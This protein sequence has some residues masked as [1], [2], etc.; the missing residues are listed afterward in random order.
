MIY[1]VEKERFIKFLY[2][3]FF[4]VGLIAIW[5]S[6]M[7]F[8]T[9]SW[10]FLGQVFGVWGLTALSLQ[11]LLGSR[12][13]VLER[14]IGLDRILKIH[15]LNGR[16]LFIFVL[17]HP[18]VLFAPTLFGGLSLTQLLSSFTIYHWMGVT[19]LVL[20]IFILAT[21]IYSAA[22]RVNYEVWKVLHKI[23]Y[24][25]IILGFAHSFYLGSD[26]TSKGVL[27][28]WWIVL[29]T[30]ALLGISYR[31]IIKSWIFRNSWYK[32]IDVI[33]E[34]H[35]IRTII[36]E[37]L[38]GKVFNFVPGQF[39]YVNFYSQQVPKEEHH[40]TISSAPNPNYLSFSIKASGDFTSKLGDLKIGEKAKI[41]GPYGVFTNT[42]MKEPFLFIAGGIGITPVMSILRKMQSEKIK[43]QSVLIYANK[44]PEDTAF[45]DELNIME[46]QGLIKIVYVFSNE[47]EIKFNK[48]FYQGKVE[49][50]I[51]KT[52]VK[53]IKNDTVFLVGPP[54]MIDA[55]QQILQNLGVDKRKIFTEKFSL[56]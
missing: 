23:A 44:S 4:L 32:V 13:P 8:F 49:E 18:I 51:L 31:Y 45:E 43:G 34:T 24:V 1:N 53:D 17:L 3:A 2:I 19:A 9:L 35:D 11:P 30:L 14:G 5:A 16:L 40:F 37:P 21:T 6:Q 42:G 33:Q 12:M 46:R 20:I 27:F 7:Q 15:A 50:N 10:Y 47:G 41:E 36:L 52:E 56:K 25:V 22:M 55:L 38:V 26:I 28:Y 48:K 54:P 29:G 39:A